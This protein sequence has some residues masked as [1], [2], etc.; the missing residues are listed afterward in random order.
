MP[1][2]QS[3]QGSDVYDDYSADD[4][5]MG[6]LSTVIEEIEEGEHPRDDVE[7]EHNDEIDELSGEWCPSYFHMCLAVA[8]SCLP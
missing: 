1:P 2:E 6:D 3:D 7:S 4:I 5:P 8:D